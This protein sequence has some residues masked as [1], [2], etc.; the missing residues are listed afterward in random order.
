MKTSRYCSQ[1]CGSDYRRKNLHL[2]N[3]TA[4]PEVFCPTCGAPFKKKSKTQK[5]CTPKCR[6]RFDSSSPEFRDRR[7]WRSYRLRLS[8]VQTVLKKQQNCCPICDRPFGNSKKSRGWVIDHDHSCCSGNKACGECNRGVICGGCNTMLGL[9][10]DSASVV[11]RAVGYLASG[12]RLERPD[13]TLSRCLI[14][15]TEFKPYRSTSKYC[16]K[17][18]QG[19]AGRSRMKLETQ[20]SFEE[21][22]CVHCGVLFLQKHTDQ[23]FCSRDCTVRGWSGDRFQFSNYGTT[24]DVIEA[25]LRSQGNKCRI[26]RTKFSGRAKKGPH[27]DHDHGCCRSVPTCGACNRGIIC[28]N[29]NGVLGMAEDSIVTL[30]RAVGY[31]RSPVRLRSN[32]A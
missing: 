13:L 30:E 16:S 28:G 18:C 4:E 15:T 32:D 17:K 10:M 12:R 19:A 8:D 21:R 11:A 1:L 23:T 9:G 31:L 5:F 22:A 20:A 25:E 24:K 2:V 7:L 3:G 26:C 6:G 27:I 14:C 29:C